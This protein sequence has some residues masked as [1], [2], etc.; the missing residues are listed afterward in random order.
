MCARAGDM[1]FSPILHNKKP[2]SHKIMKCIQNFI[3][4]KIKAS[5]VTHFG[6]TTI[7]LLNVV[8]EKSQGDT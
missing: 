4:W 5:Y 6:K 2:I 3:C 7:N 8:S 1:H